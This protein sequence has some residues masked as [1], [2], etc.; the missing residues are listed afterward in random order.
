[1]RG[2]LTRRYAKGKVKIEGV[3]PNCGASDK[4]GFAD[5]YY[6]N[7]PKPFAINMPICSNCHYDEIRLRK[8]N[9]R[10]YKVNEVQWDEYY[11]NLSKYRDYSGEDDCTF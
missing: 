7:E 8:I 5:L 11:E 3:C 1:M 9:N 6:T 10:R 4:V 2:K